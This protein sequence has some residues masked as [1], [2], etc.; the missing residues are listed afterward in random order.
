MTRRWS[1]RTLSFAVLAGA[2]LLGVFTAW[3]IS[4]GIVGGRL[5]GAL[6]PGDAA[7]VLAA[8]GDGFLAAAAIALLLAGLGTLLLGALVGRPL[9]AVRGYLHARARGAA[10]TA[11]STPVAE[12]RALAGAVDL[13]VRERDARAA[14]LEQERDAFALLV[15]S[16]SE[17]ILQI[18][19]DGRIVHANPAARGMLGLPDD[20]RGRP[21]GALIR[22]TE[23]RPLLEQAAAGTAQGTFEVALDDR[24]MLVFARQI[25]AQGPDARAGAVVSLADLTELR[26]LEGVRRDFV[27]NVSH[28][29]KTPLTSIR[30]YV[31][32]LLG[33]D[34]GAETRQHFLAVVQRNAERLQRIVDDLLDLSRIESGGWRPDLQPTDVRA[35]A[36]TAWSG[37]EDRA[38]AGRIAFDITG[39]AAAALA[40]PD[41]LH[42]VLSNVFDNAVRYTPAGG[43]IVVRIAREPSGNGSAP[44]AERAAGSVIVEVR[45][46]GS[47]IPSDA[48]PRIFE[49]FY[50]VDPARSRDAG[51]T[52]LGL[53]IVRHLMERMGGEVGAESELGKGTTIRLRLPA[54]VP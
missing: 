11:P 19:P 23:L 5:A 22:S 40:D 27:A 33:E 1:F 43:R 4:R 37:C 36:G 35:A 31:E 24:R 53:A 2:L 48:L 21:V 46:S 54:A 8:L 29:L 7:D 34:P 50:R 16:V 51:G 20:V 14:Q 26:R 18:D 42:Q 41:G 17:G 13:L 28:E 10:A 12:L 45:D 44:A 30:G 47:G 15:G 9:D 49:R 25:P 39:D 6:P 32:T 3:R 38:R 52:G